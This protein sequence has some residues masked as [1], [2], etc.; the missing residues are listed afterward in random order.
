MHR[1]FA[2][3]F[4][5]FTPNAK[6]KHGDIMAIRTKVQTASVHREIVCSGLDAQHKETLFSMLQ[7]DAS[8]RTVRRQIAAFK[9][10]EA[11]IERPHLGLP[12]YCRRRA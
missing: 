2:F 3:I 7:K 1:R 8:P 5:A 6:T 9:V 10:A 12:K 11:A 4:C